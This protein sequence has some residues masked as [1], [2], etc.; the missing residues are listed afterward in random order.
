MSVSL[1]ALRTFDSDHPGGAGLSDLGLTLLDPLEDPWC[2]ETPSNTRV[3]ATTGGDSVHFC[4]LD[5]GGDT[6]ETSPILMVV[7]CNP[8]M[9]RMVLGD[10]LHEFLAL[11]SVIGFFFLE[12][13]TYDFDRTLPILFDW[14][15]F[16]LDSYFG[17]PPP[18][19]DLADLATQRELLKQLSETFG[20]APW[21]NARERIAELQSRWTPSLRIGT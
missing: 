5:L 18:A 9:P 4:L 12:Q 10:S 15:A 17:Q 3:F 7:P 16:L 14:E 11:G 13:L 2:E 8:D 1:D 19:E 6:K 21:P 20:L